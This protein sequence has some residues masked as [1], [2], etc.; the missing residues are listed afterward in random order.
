MQ[1]QDVMVLESSRERPEHFS[2]W[3]E[4]VAGL[5]ETLALDPRSAYRRN[6]CRDV[7]YPVYYD[8]LN[9]CCKF[10]DADAPHT[11]S[12][13]VMNIS[14][15]H[16]PVDGSLAGSLGPLEEPGAQV[17]DEK[18]NTQRRRDGRM[19][20]NFSEISVK[21]GTRLPDAL[22]SSFPQFFPSISSA[23]KAIRRREVN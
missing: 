20:L 19:D 5:Q 10:L 16:G 6:K 15:R 14:L 8:R 3:R 1:G 9:V 18:L 23:R 2:S 21:A 13:Q 12:V 17:A 7:V 11:E 22:F 4:A